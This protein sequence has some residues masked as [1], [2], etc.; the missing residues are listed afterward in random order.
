MPRFYIFRHSNILLKLL[1]SE[2]THFI[3]KNNNDW[4]IEFSGF[5][6]ANTLELFGAY[7][8]L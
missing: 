1:F 8:V 6:A 5:T 2:K 3:N 4:W 7:F